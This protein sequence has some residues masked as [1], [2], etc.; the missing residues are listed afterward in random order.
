L[1]LDV[2]PLLGLSFTEIAAVV[3]FLESLTGEAPK[4]SPPE[5]P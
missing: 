3:A 4:I 2:K 1:S 5:L